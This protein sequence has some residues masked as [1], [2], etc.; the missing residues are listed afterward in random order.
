MKWWVKSHSEINY[1][2][3]A[4]RFEI[5]AGV[6]MFFNEENEAIWVIKDWTCFQIDYE[7]AQTPDEFYENLENDERC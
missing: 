1:N 7:K 5:H 3:E 6:L 2:V 4:D